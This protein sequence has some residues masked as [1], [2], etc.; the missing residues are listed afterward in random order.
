MS[1]NERKRK[2]EEKEE[3]RIS[4][5]RVLHYE[6]IALGKALPKEGNDFEESLGHRPPGGW[7]GGWPNL[8]ESAYGLKKGESGVTVLKVLDEHQLHKAR[9]EMEKACEEFSEFNFNGQSFDD[10]SHKLAMG[11]FRGDAP[12]TFVHST[13]DNTDFYQQVLEF[14]LRSTTCS[15]AR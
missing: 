7:P 1:A 3:E 15:S 11:A 13:P 8:Q 9:Q 14:H 4:R 10:I 6:K 2:C 5:Q 12:V